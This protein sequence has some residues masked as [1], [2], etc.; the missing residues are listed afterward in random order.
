STGAV[1]VP[2][3]NGPGDVAFEFFLET[4][5]PTFLFFNV[6]LYRYSHASRVVTPVIVPC[7]TPAPQGGTFVVAWLHPSLNNKGDLVFTAVFPTEA[8]AAGNRPGLGPGIFKAD[9]NT[10]GISSLVLPGDRAPGGSTFDFSEHPW[11][12]N[13]GDVAFEAHVAVEECI[14]IF[15]PDFPFFCGESVYLMTAATG[16]IR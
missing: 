2:S 5:N 4:C 10:A 12:N 6:G 1:P 7:V 9:E 14:P 3:L 11:I 16:E 13:R 15:A 8:A